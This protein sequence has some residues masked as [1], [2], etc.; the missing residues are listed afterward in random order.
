MCVCLLELERAAAAPATHADPLTRARPEAPYKGSGPCQRAIS[1]SMAQRCDC[2]ACAAAPGSKMGGTIAEVVAAV[3]K[4]ATKASD[5][6]LDPA[7]APWMLAAAA[8]LMRAAADMVRTEGDFMRAAADMVHAKGLA[9]LNHAR[10]KNLYARAEIIS[11]RTATMRRAE[12]AAAAWKTLSQCAHAQRDCDA[13][14]AR[15]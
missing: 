1:P 6:P 15:R 2:E 13:A 7:H 12:V 4:I 5:G 11:E 8:D 3:A 10:A 9:A 14:A